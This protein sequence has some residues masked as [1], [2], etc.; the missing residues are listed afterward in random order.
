VLQRV[1][2]KGPAKT[3]KCGCGGRARLMVQSP[4]VQTWTPLFLEH[5]SHE[6]KYF[7]TKAS[8]KQH[9]RENGVA[10]NALL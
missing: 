3:T 10:S 1:V 9:C 5:V 2:G 4:Q 8:L 6:G 7:P